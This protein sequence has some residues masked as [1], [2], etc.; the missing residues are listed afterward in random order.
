[1]IIDPTKHFHPNRRP[2]TCLSAV[3]CVLAEINVGE[4]VN[5]EGLLDASGN[6]KPLDLLQTI[7]G[8]L[9]GK[10]VFQTRRA[11]APMLATIRRIS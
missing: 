1:M 6:T 8:K 11:P 7:V 5:V 10:S 9:R 3:A 4:V 2:Y